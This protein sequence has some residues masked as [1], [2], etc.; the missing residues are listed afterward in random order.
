MKKDYKI[1]SIEVVKME[2]VLLSGSD[3]NAHNQG[4]S[5]NQFAPGYGGKGR[6]RYAEDNLDDE[7]EEEEF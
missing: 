6:G 7:E 2:Q 1:P 4:G 3:P 5:G